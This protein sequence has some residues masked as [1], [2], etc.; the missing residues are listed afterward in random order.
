[1]NHDMQ[2]SNIK[3]TSNIMADVARQ[4]YAR[5]QIGKAVIVTDQPTEAQRLL[6]RLWFR[7][8][9]KL[10][11]QRA[12]TDNGAIIADL[13]RA[14]SLLQTMHFTTLAPFEAPHNDMFIMTPEGLEDILPECHTLFIATPVSEAL[15]NQAIVC[16]QP[17]ARLFA[18]YEHANT[19]R[20]Q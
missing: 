7:L 2:I 12:L 11:I 13:S 9:R 20:K 15:L 18:Y 17:N 19:A 3:G 14:I 5:A 6:Q 4:L 10:Q 8:I 1:M 16:L